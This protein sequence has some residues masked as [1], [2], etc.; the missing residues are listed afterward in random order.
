MKPCWR[1]HCGTASAC[2]T[3]AATGLAVQAVLAALMELE[4]AGA[5]VD[6]GGGRYTAA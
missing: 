6:N 3:A 5:A 1:L 4:F 2:P